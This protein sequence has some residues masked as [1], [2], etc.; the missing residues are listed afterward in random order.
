MKTVIITSNHD[1]NIFELFM[2]MI[3]DRKV[4]TFV[5]MDFK[6]KGWEKIYFKIKNLILERKDSNTALLKKYGISFIINENANSEEVFNFLKEKKIE[7]IISCNNHSILKKR[8]LNEF[9]CINIHHG[10]LPEY[11]GTGRPW[12]K[13]L[14]KG[15]KITG[16][17]VH[18]MN[19]KIDNGKI[20]S[21][22]E[23]EVADI[24]SVTT[25]VNNEVKKI[26]E[27]LL[28]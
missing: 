24:Q 26:L 15:E 6:R 18:E 5:L 21:R 13:P 9:R 19:E 23:I 11:P 16:V 25:L 2:D 17:T 3:K 20:I 28:K 10:L 14:Q 8:I 1:N 22:H 12:L 4:S 27:D 7:R